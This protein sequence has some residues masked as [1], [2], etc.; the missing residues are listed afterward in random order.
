MT[1]A[2]DRPRNP[3]GFR[4]GAAWPGTCNPAPVSS[5]GHSLRG[6]EEEAMRR[7]V[8]LICSILLFIP[9][10]ATPSSA[11]P[12]AADSGFQ[13]RFGGF[14]PEGGGDLWDENEFVF[15]QDVSD[16]D[17]FVLGFSYVTGM[18]NYMEV[19]FNADFYDGEDFSSYRDYVD[20]EGFPIYHDTELELVPLTLDVRFLP[21]GRYRVRPQGRQVLKPVLYF[22]G[23]LGVTLWE[24]REI[25]DFIDFDD[26]MQS[27][28]YGDFQDSGTAF[29]T[30]VLAGIELPAGRGFNILFEGRYAW[31]DDELGDDFA[32]LGKIELGGYSFFGG[33]GWRF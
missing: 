2:V 14:F 22:G 27:I 11:G 4:F 1:A 18:G 17:D 28:F 15:T 7:P 26:P 12:G 10:C 23:G 33:F 8:P 3:G 5:A 19:G 32:G 24:Y 29:E 9:L 20:S 21:G 13:L 30:H 31:V 16:F 25:G 6:A